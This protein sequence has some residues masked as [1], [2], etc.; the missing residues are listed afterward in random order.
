VEHLKEL[1]IDEHGKPLQLINRWLEIS[2]RFLAYI[3]AIM[4]ILMALITTYSVVRRYLFQDADNNA[5]LA[6]CVITLF[7]ASFSWAEIQRQ[8][9]HIVV[10]YFSDRF[11]ENVKEIILDALSPVFGLI[12]CVILLWKNVAGALFSLEIG[13]RTLTSIA[14]PVFP[15]K[16]VIIIGVALLCLVLLLQL[17]N[18]L[19]V[20]WTRVA[21]KKQHQP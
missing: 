16:V 14:L 3:S 17:I 12:F 18:Y 20:L 10:D 7:F 1:K 2:T 21:R 8:K 11:S 15:L 5:F 6:I 4:V 13:E 19:A 9:R